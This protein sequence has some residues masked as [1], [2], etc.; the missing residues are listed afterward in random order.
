METLKKW[1]VVAAVI[2]FTVAFPIAGHTPLQWGLRG[3]NL[4]LG[5]V[6]ELVNS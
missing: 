4:V 1:Y 5:T 2:C 3:L 6:N